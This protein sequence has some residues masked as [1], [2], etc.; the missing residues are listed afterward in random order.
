MTPTPDAP[1]ADRLDAAVRDVGNPC[2]VGID[3][4]L[5]LLPEEFAGAA[6]PSRPLEE[7]ADL[8]AAFGRGLVEVAAGAVAAVKPQSAFFE[9]LGAPGVRAFGEVCAAAREAGL[10]VVGDVKRGDI[11]STAAAYA[12][13]YMGEDAPLR[14]DAITV[15]PLLG[16]DSM[17]PLLERAQETGGGLFVLVRTSNTGSAD[18]QGLEA[19]RGEDG[20][21][22][23][24]H[25]HLADLVHA[26]GEALVGAS[27]LSSVGAVVGATHPEHVAALRA[28]MPRTPLLL[29]GLGAQ[30]G[31]PAD[32]AAGFLADDQPFRG[33]L[34]PAS[35][36]VSFAHRKGPNAGQPWRDAARRALD[37]LV[38]EVTGALGA[39]ASSGAG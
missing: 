31:D 28:R 18:V 39:A 34:V 6:D 9:A 17:E 38:A 22:R 16:G 14:C 20:E 2:C 24:V 1:F 33:G 7:R 23:P 12:R 27:G 26:W 21:V 4:H 19:R 35:R 3:P 25:A 11:G 37:D 30:G 13:A 15:N 10:L 36:S 8:V 5:D 29:P 32:V